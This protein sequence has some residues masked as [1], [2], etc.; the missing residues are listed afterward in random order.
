MRMRELRKAKGMTMK[1]LGEVLGV[2][3]ST[4]SQYETGKREPDFEILLKASEYFGVT[5]DY[6]L[7]RETPHKQPDP[8]EEADLAFYDRYKSLSESEKE[9]MRDF[10]KLTEERR[11]RREKE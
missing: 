9:D 4:I 10:L 1:A 11:K 6:L 7:E 5:V 2:A 8:L 3:E